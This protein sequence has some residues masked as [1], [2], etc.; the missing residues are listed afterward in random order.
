MICIAIVIVVANS[1][2]LDHLQ[3]I[4]APP[5]KRK[6][7]KNRGG[8]KS[9]EIELAEGSKKNGVKDRSRCQ[10]VAR[11]RQWGHIGFFVRR[12]MT[13][14]KCFQNTFFIF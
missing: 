14:L 3:D 9:K 10:A 1:Q 12:E 11:L 5:T 6:K 13:S 2:T 7:M 4:Q 8:R